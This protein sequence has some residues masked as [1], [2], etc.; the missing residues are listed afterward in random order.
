M[1]SSYKTLS[2][3]K[4]DTKIWFG[5]V[6]LILQPFLETQSCTKFVKSAQAI[7]SGYSRSI[8]SFVVCLHGS[9]GFRATMYGWQKK[10]IIHW[11]RCHENEEKIDNDY[12]LRNDPW[13]QNYSTNSNDLIIILFRRLKVLGKSVGL[14]KTTKRKDQL[15][16]SL[17]VSVWRII[18]EKFQ[19]KRTHISWDMNEN[20][21]KENKKNSGF[22]EA[23]Q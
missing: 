2:S 13:N 21:N 3:K 9:I 19:P 20:I 11:L 22:G 18:C 7:Y 17:F 8:R 10:T 5:S 12:V 14:C 15:Y 1:I 4:N 16:I 6:V 23:L